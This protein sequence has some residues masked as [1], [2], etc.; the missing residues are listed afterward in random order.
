MSSGVAVVFDSTTLLVV[1]GLNPQV[2][3]ETLYALA[4]QQPPVVP[5]E[6]HVLTTSEGAQRARLT[7][8]S[9]RPGWFRQLLADYRLGDVTFDDEHIHVL[10]DRAGHPLADIRTADDNRATAD[11]VAELVRR[12]TRDEATA[13]HVSLA[14]GRKTL[15]FFAGYALGLWG[16]PQDSLSHVL[17]DEPFESSWEFFYPTPYERI[18]QTR[19]HK[20][21]DCAEAKVTLADIPFV[22]LRH[23]LPQR[24]LEGRASFAEAVQAAQGHLGPPSL[25]LA[26]E[27]QR[28]T[29]GGQEIALPP[30]ELAFLA[31]FARRVITGEPALPCPKDG[32]PNQDY[33][34]AYLREYRLIVGPLGDD[35]RTRRRYRDGMTKSDFEERKSKLKRVLVDALGAAAVPYLIE[36]IGR[37]PM[38][39]RLRL[40]PSAITFSDARPPDVA[41]LRPAAVTKTSSDDGAKR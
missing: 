31:W 23:G 11:Q 25:K 17:V 28:V 3:T 24:L 14:G 37:N 19:D 5:R 20:V 32:V 13:L 18:I 12:L 1:S 4:M 41:S 8:L 21:V 7:L 9:E 15:G 22:R 35:E 10:H 29:A 36:G 16:R 40:R 30:A 34:D 33:R 2:V 6:V 27:G 38:R 26:L 39:Y